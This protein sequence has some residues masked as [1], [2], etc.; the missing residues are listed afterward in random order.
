MSYRLSGYRE[1]ERSLLPVSGNVLQRIY[2]AEP[3][4]VTIL[5]ELSQLFEFYMFASMALY[6]VYHH[7]QHSAVETVSLNTLTITVAFN[8]CGY[9][10]IN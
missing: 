8:R 5:T 1:D 6:I 9:M 10:L 4:L 7:P 2:H 3:S